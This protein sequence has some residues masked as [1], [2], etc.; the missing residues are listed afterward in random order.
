MQTSPCKLRGL[1]FAH[2]CAQE[3]ISVALSDQRTNK[4]F[5][6]LSS[7]TSSRTTRQDQ[8]VSRWAT[9]FDYKDR[10]LPLS[11]VYFILSSCYLFESHSFPVL[12]FASAGSAG[13]Y[14]IN[15]LVQSSPLF[16]YLSSLFVFEERAVLCYS[17]LYS[18]ATPVQA[19]MLSLWSL[20][21][22]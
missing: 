3:N 17:R 4:I 10:N 9:C 11:P 6:C 5:M 7:F 14:R 8:C 13:L 2:R 22:D 12:R 15:L 1:V 19:P 18:L 20:R 16:F 21:S